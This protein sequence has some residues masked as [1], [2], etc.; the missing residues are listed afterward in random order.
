MLRPY[1]IETS[2]GATYAVWAETPQ[3][4][5]ETIQQEE[6]EK[7]TSLTL[8]PAT[9]A[10][11]RGSLQRYLYNKGIRLQGKSSDEEGFNVTL[12]DD[13]WTFA[14]GTKDEHIPLT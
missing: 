10:E 8:V 14:Y 4:A 11:T 1:V 13:T 12:R 7:P 6:D 5:K 2:A 9:D 3:K